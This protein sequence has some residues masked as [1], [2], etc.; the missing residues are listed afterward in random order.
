MRYS[1]TLRLSAVVIFKIVYFDGIIQTQL[2][3]GSGAVELWKWKAN[4]LALIFLRVS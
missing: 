1:A 4:S 2:R 3:I